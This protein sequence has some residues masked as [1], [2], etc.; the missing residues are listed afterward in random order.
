MAVTRTFCHLLKTVAYCEACNTRL[1]LADLRQLKCPECAAILENISDAE[2]DKLSGLDIAPLPASYRQKTLLPPESGESETWHLDHEPSSES[3]LEPAVAIA[4]ETVPE[5]VPTPSL[6][7]APTTALAP[8]VAAPR[9]SVR[10]SA[11]TP[12]SVA[13]APDSAPKVKKRRAKRKRSKKERAIQV[14]TVH[15]QRQYRKKLRELDEF[16]IEYA[17]R[18]E[19]NPVS[20]AALTEIH[21]HG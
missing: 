1:S 19:L 6:P 11:M 12:R 20:E 13:P 18:L 16:L 17:E 2:F 21:K 9:R 14:M 5:P 3:S 15:E 7:T 8:S 10:A 4:H